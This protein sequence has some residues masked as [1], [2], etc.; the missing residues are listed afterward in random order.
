MAQQ[1]PEHSASRT[2]L[3]EFV[4]DQAHDKAHLFVWVESDLAGR[5]LHISARQIEKQLA[6]LGLEK[7][8]LLKTVAHGVQL[9]RAHGSLEPKQQTIV[10]ICWIIN[11]ILVSKDRVKDG[12]YLQEM[13]PV[14]VGPRQSAHL[15]SQHDAHMVHRDLG[16]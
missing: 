8:A 12:A 15:Q 10:G 9:Q 13:M 5:K 4:E 14:L 7:P 11:P 3:G 1:V 2:Q 6:S 16:Q